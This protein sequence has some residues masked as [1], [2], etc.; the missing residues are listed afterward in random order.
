MWG[1]LAKV[2]VPKPKIVKIGQKTIDCIFIGY[3]SNICAY[4]F[5]VHKSQS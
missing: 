5:L 2:V 3:V 1:W 4:R